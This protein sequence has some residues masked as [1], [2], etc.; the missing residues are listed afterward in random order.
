MSNF[1]IDYYKILG[2]SKKSST[3]EIKKAYRKLAI[4]YH[5]DK[6]P[7]NIEAERKFQEIN[8][9]YEILSDPKQRKMYDNYKNS[10]FRFDFASK[11]SSSSDFFNGFD[12][13][14]NE[15][16]GTSFDKENKSSK[17]K[18]PRRGR[19][20]RYELTL[21]L[22]EAS[23]GKQ[24]EME[25]P[26]EEFCTLCNGTGANQGSSKNICN[27]CNGT[28]QVSRS[29]GFFNI[30]YSC[31]DC[32]GT[33]IEIESP[34]PKCKGRGVID[35]HK[36]ITLNIPAGVDSGTKLKYS[37]QGSS[38]INGGYSGDLFI[39]ITVK[40]HNTFLRDG[41]DLIYN[42]NISY[43]DAVFG[44]EKFV[45]TL[46][47]DRIKINIPSGTQNG[48]KFVIKNHGIKDLNSDN[49]G[50]LLVITNIIIP[51]KLTQKQKELLL[52]FEKEMKKN[53]NY[54]KVYDKSQ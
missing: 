49:I 1:K 40:P 5:P 21:T 30:K 7:G 42:L 36:K 29:Q 19:D 14:F 20:I 9:A 24:I 4:K 32:G 46:N 54:N 31:P 11:N 22:K 27:T 50:N 10:P 48:S 8:E 2:I 16:F 17:S 33:G 18:T 26:R 35:N 34:C 52:E 44:C 13:L 12:D 45:N 25:I 15:F 51:T 3:E 47:G 23:S 28:G 53:D 38:G 39:L 6:N 41:T 37:G 43:T